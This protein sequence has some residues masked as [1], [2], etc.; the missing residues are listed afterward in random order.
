V[1]VPS[2]HDLLLALGDDL[3]V[4]L[5]VGRAP[6]GELIYANRTFAEIMGRD[7]RADLRV[8]GYAEPY[9]I[10]TR[11]GVLYPE[12]K[13]PFVR[14][15]TERRVVSADDITIRRPDGKHVEIRAVA[16]PVGD[17]TTHVIVTFFDI[18][19][20]VAA[21]RARAQSE[22][23]LRRAQRFEAIGTLAGGLAHDFN[24]LIF[25]IKL[26]AAEVA[27]ADQDPKRR[28]T[29]ELIDDIT[30]RSA[31]L[32]RSLLGFTRRSTQRAMPIGMN[33]V[34]LSLT[35]LL[36]RTLSGVELTFELEAS[37]RGTVVGDH[38]QLEQMIVNLVLNAQGAGRVIVRT[39]DRP[40][41]GDPA[42]QRSVVLEVKDDGPGILAEVSE[43]V[44]DPN[45]TAGAPPA[46][47]GLG[48]ET[49]F[50]IIES[51]S[52]TLEVDAGIDG[53][54]TTM[55]VVLPGARLA[56]AAKLRTTLDDLPRGSGLIL[57]VD[58]DPMV[59]KV[60]AG[61]LG[62]LGYD[63]IEAMSGANAVEIF[64]ARHAEIRGV[65]LDM[66]MPGMPGK[67]TYLALREVDPNV[68]VMLMSGHSLNDQVQEILD[69]GVRSFVSKPYSL[70]ALATAMAAL[71][72]R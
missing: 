64:R 30:E 72:R 69:L 7:A 31:T 55:R 71:V 12:S 67:A 27:M 42:G 16:R 8:G 66:M 36:G 38:A 45:D 62:S 54:G 29:M 37:E 35:E 26:L 52:G 17:P 23:R 60:V 41:P 10:Y 5:W 13:L 1:A 19:R 47:S 20:E 68:S 59:R 21:E 50:A 43:R 57:I 18:G 6:H 44:I 53:R 49:V 56:P 48:L 40:T 61:S 51:H 4:G 70:A 15:L 33:D 39:A 63:A 2:D 46:G 32:T 34:V 28:A 58:D 14:A 11:D 24:N 22:Q 9:G 65:V 3:P 25:G